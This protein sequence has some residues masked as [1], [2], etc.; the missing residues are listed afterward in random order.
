MTISMATVDYHIFQMQTEAA[1]E[2]IL[3]ATQ[4]LRLVL[5]NPRGKKP[6]KEKGKWEG[7]WRS[8]NCNLTYRK[9]KIALPFLVAE[10]QAMETL[11]QNAK[12]MYVCI[13]LHI[14]TSAFACNNCQG[15]G[16]I[17]VILN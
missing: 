3:R 4:S 15:K 13:S 12:N 17:L 5:S 2:G 8:R 14:P 7:N 16:R 10:Q 9:N 11:Y 6:G 1:G